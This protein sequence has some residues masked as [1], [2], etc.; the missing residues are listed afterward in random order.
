MVVTGAET[1]SFCGDL[2]GV[3]LQPGE[4]EPCV[5]NVECVCSF[6]SNYDIG[7]ADP[8]KEDWISLVLSED[9]DSVWKLRL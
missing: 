8:S 4:T 3:D 2:F 6:S 9:D 5:V 7:F 1:T